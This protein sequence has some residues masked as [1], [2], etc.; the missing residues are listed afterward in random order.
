MISIL[1]ATYNGEKYIKESI[2]SVLN[3]TF[4]NIELIIGLNGTTDGSKSVIDRF[5]DNRIRLFDYGNN[6]GKARTLNKLIRES[7]NNFICVQD[8]DDIW[9]GDK[10]EKQ[11]RYVDLYDVIGTFIK[12]IDPNGN[13]IGHPNLQEDDDLIKR[14]SMSGD[15]QI[16]NTSAIFRKSDVIEIG[17]WKEDID[18]IEDY[19]LWL[20]LMRSGK[21]FIN[22]PEYLVLHR[23]H[24]QSNF[25][26]KRHDISKIL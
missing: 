20:R 16:A 8:D 3:Q 1:M 17:G 26:T 9:V 11:L 22:I 23:I 14:L 18:G 4:K 19:D 2:E 12:Y 10:L 15:N 21:K 24:N 25:N 5:N 6:R 13:I 7:E